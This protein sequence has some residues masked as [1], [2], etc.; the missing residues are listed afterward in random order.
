M[1]LGFDH[2]HGQGQGHGT[3]RHGTVGKIHVHVPKTKL[4]L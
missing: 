1:Y 3:E 4:S 2:D